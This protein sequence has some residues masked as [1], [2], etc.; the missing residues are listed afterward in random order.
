MEDSFNDSEASKK[1]M[2][3]F[4]DKNYPRNSIK[5]KFFGTDRANS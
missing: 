2:K 1:V 4:F 5:L 3:L